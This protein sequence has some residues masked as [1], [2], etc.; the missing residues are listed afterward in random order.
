MA[1]CC[2]N[3]HANP[4]GSIWCRECGS[5]VA[6]ARIGS[7]YEA[8][9]FVGQ[10][11]ASAVY[12]ANQLS[13]DNRKVVVKVLPPFGSHAAVADFRREAALLASL[14]HPYILPIYAYGIV[15]ERHAGPSSYSPYLVLPYVRQGSLEEIFLRGGRAPWSLQ[16]VVPIIADVAE[17]LD[18]AHARGVLH[19]DVKPA[20]LLLY[21][22]HVL[23]ADFGVAALIDSSMSHLTTGWA[24]SPAFMAPE[25]WLF[26]PGRYSDQY[27][28]AVTCYRLLTGN[29]PWRNLAGDVASWSHLHRYIAPDPLHLYRPD[30]PRE[31]GMV[32]QHALAKNPHAR[33]SSV[34]MFADDLRMAMVPSSRNVS[35]GALPWM[36]Q[37][38]VQPPIPMPV[39]VS[40]AQV[41]HH[42]MDEDQDVAVAV[43]SAVSSMLSLSGDGFANW[44]WYGWILTVLV[45][46]VLVAQVWWRNGS[47]RGL[48]MIFVICPGILMAP[49]V[50]SLFRKVRIVSSLRG[51]LWGVFLALTELVCSSPVCYSWTALGR[52]FM[53]WG[54]LWRRSGDGWPIFESEFVK[55]LPQAIPVFFTACICILP[56]G[57]LVGLLVARS[58][59]LRQKMVY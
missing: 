23:L 54:G 47:T 35:A 5:L 30:V 27:A 48:F 42:K 52:T 46:L 50:A 41:S 13:L 20:N 31:V 17:A 44:V 51:I 34:R 16:R 45:C 26:R 2:M 39:Q 53:Q 22:S 56:A 7:D 21:D 6:G 40:V 32:L 11:S 25:V 9:S 33:Y 24:G 19:R 29:Y 43:G 12:L 18:Y 3:Q 38:P 14:A 15:G 55:L 1:L 57:V 8:V 37:S 59:R 4:A 58:Q 28:L 49:L 36:V 10:G